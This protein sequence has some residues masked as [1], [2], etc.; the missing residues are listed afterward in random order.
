MSR[1]LLFVTK[2]YSLSVLQPL[3]NYINGRGDTARWY[4]GGSASKLVAPGQAL[5]GNS[6]VFDFQPTAVLVPGNVVPHYWPGLKVQI[7]HGLGEEKPGH[8]RITGFFDLYCT[9]GPYITSRFDKLAG[10]HG[11]FLVR[12]T[13]WPKLG[14][15]TR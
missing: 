8:Y 7:F 1:Y 15:I 2:S 6:Q 14:G 9:P 11:H 10:K 4:M 5:R 12:E 3:A 13:G